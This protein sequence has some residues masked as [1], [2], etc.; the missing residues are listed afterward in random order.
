[1]LVDVMI[2]FCSKTTY[3]N[4]IVLGLNLEG[5]VKWAAFCPRLKNLYM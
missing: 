3:N 5:Y 4:C 2:D 1:M